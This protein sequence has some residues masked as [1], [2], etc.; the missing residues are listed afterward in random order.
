MAG[1]KHGDWN[2]G[3]CGLLLSMPWKEADC[4]EDFPFASSFLWNEETTGMLV[5]RDRQNT[6]ISRT[7]SRPKLFSSPFS[8]P[9]EVSPAPKED[10]VSAKHSIHP[11]ILPQSSP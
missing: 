9:G 1:G 2:G 5:H 11:W 4:R 6:R 10:A 8:F 7:Y 3:V